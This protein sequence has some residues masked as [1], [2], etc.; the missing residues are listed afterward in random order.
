MNVV[1]F[2]CT[3]FSE[4]ILKE[5][6]KIK[7]INIEAIF[8]IPSNFSISY[9]K[10]KVK[11]TN[12]K[13]LSI[14]AD[15]LE[16][17]IYWVDSKKGNKITNYSNTIKKINPDIILVMGWY[18]MVPKEIREIAKYGA[19]GI[20]ASILPNYAGGAPLVWAIIEGQ[21]STGVTLFRLS[22]GVDDGDII[23]QDEFIIEENDT[24][25]EVYEKATVSS[26]KLLKEVFSKD[27]KE[28]NFKVQDKSKIKIYPQRSPEDGEINWNWSIK[29]IRDFIRAQTKP[30]PG[31]WTIINNKKIILWD[32]SIYNIKD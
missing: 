22:D 28:V 18:Y 24:I 23:S 4:K 30:Y 15:Q 10:E 2:G 26:V 29:K 13:D 32:A 17:P 8:S 31:A 1:F 5:L 20:H 3:S 21:N 27:L 14:Y 6:I 16:I 11:N 12:F 7:H 25:R 9:N 19:W